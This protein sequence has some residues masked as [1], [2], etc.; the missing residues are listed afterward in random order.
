MGENSPQS[1]EIKKLE[2]RAEK[3]M[4][5]ERAELYRDLGVLLRQ[6]LRAILNTR[7]ARRVI[8]FFARFLRIRS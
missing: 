5:P 4:G 6:L 1:S 2:R 7:L 3:D 8:T